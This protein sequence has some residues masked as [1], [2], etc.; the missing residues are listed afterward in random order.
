MSSS[1]A[2]NSIFHLL[3][4]DA[5]SAKPRTTNHWRFFVVVIVDWI[6]RWTLSVG[7]VLNNPL[8]HKGLRHSQHSRWKWFRS[9]SL[10]GARLLWGQKGIRVRWWWFI[11]IA[12][13]I[14]TTII[15]EWVNESLWRN[16]TRCVAIVHR[17]RILLCTWNLSTH[18]NH[19]LFLVVW[20]T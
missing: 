16:E 4:A 8:A 3:N 9:A 12:R 19:L 1:H 18:D 13:T 15:I 17:P 5:C 10:K 7:G 14:C 6:C 2:F 20:P 11:A